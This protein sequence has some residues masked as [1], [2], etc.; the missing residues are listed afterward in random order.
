MLKVKMLS[1]TQR[2]PILF[3]LSRFGFN[4]VCFFDLI[5]EKN[6]TLI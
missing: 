4:L 6:D 1:L 3:Q 5:I 2:R